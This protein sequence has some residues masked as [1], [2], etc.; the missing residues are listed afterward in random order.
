MILGD[1]EL[2]ESLQ[3]LAGEGVFFTGNVP[4]AR[5]YMQAFD[6]L[7]YPAVADSFG[8]VVLEAMDAGVPVVTQRQHGPAYVLGDLGCYATDDSPEAY[9]LA[10][11]K[12]LTMDRSMLQIQGQERISQ[13]FSV[14]AM[15]RMLDHLMIEGVTPGW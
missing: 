9:A 1:G 15:A 6:V 11:H 10:L 8:M 13:Q 12:A 3:A 7:L 4:Q 2:R 5:N 14:S